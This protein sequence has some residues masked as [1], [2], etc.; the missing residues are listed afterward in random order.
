M[1]GHM[2][3]PVMPPLEIKSIIMT[4]DNVYVD[5]NHDAVCSI[6]YYICI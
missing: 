3:A 2:P 6:D 1:I 4:H 5:E